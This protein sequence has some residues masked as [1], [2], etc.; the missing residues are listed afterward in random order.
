MR[1][2]EGRLSAFDDMEIAIVRRGLMCREHTHDAS[3]GR[4]LFARASRWSYNRA[5]E[6]GKA[7]K[8]GIK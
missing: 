2:T 5:C 4:S 1:L 7:E 3:H 6:K 8:Q